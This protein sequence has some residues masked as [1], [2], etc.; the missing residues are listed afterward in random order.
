MKMKKGFSFNGKIFANGDIVKITHLDSYEVVGVILAQEENY[1]IVFNLNGY[2]SQILHRYI[3]NITFTKSITPEARKLLKD[4]Y[5]AYTK[6]QEEK[7][8]YQRAIEPLQK[9]IKGIN[10]DTLT[11]AMGLLT[12]EDFIQEFMK[13]LPSVVEFGLQ[14]FSFEIYN[15]ILN[16]EKR[17]DI[18]KYFKPCSFVFE[19][20][21]RTLQFTTDCERDKNYQMYIKKYQCL[22]PGVKTKPHVYL[23]LGDKDWLSCTT[24]Y[25]IPLTKPFT[26]AYAKELSKKF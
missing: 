9:I 11:Q 20:Y 1:L 23:S 12:E 15:G 13:N 21:D 16:I 10:K 14:E 18:Q 19:E 17:V 22:V 24:S 2:E 5:Q 26:A 3:K 7:E 6:F 25:D 4:Y 8:R